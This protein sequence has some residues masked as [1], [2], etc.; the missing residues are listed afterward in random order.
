[1]RDASQKGMSV[2]KLTNKVGM[3]RRLYLE[4]ETFGYMIEFASLRKEE[5]IQTIT[6]RLKGKG[7]HMFLHDTEEAVRL[8]IEELVKEKRK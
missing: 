1:M 6:N 2:Q 5:I 4:A 3:A 8:V 7:L